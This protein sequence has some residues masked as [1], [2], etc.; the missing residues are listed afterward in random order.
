MKVLPLCTRTHQNDNNVVGGEEACLPAVR[1][2][3]AR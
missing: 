1:Q 2:T 3:F